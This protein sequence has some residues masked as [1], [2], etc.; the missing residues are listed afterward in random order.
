M[1]YFYLITFVLFTVVGAADFDRPDRNQSIS[2]FRIKEPIKIDGILD[3]TVWQNGHG[4]TQLVQRDPEEGA[5]PTEKTE[6][7]IAYD[8]Q[9]LYIGARLYDSSPESISA[10]LERRDAFS[11]TDMFGFFIDPYFD[12]R[13]GY[14]FALS[15]G[16]TLHDGILLNDEWDDDSWD[17]VWEGKT[18]IDDQGWNAEMRIPFSQLRFKKQEEYVWGINFRR[19]IA[20]KN[21]IIYL[22]Y[23]PRNGSGFV[24][25]FPKLTGIE[26]INPA[27]N[28]EVM[29]YV[30]AKGEFTHPD[31]GD[32]FNDGSRYLPGLGVDI[33]YGLSSNLTLNATV[34]PDFGQVEVDPAVINL[35]DVETYFNEK[36]PFFVEGSSIF[37]FGSGGSR[38]NWGFNWGNPGF[39]YSRRIGRSPQGRL[40]VHDYRDMP[41]GARILGAA[42]LTGKVGNNWNIGAIHAISAREFADIEYEGSQSRVE[43]EPLTHYSVLRVQKEMNEGF[44]GLGF[45]ST[46]AIRDFNDPRLRDDINANAYVF[47]LD[48]WTFLDKGRTW[49][50]TTWGGFS[51]L[52]GSE[53]RMLRVQTDPGHYFQR[54]DAR[55]LSPDSSATSLQGYAGRVTVNKQKG[56]VI[57]NSALGVVDPGFDVR[58][59]GFMWRTNV[60]NSHI[61]LGYKWTRPNRISRYTEVIG[62]VFNSWDFDGLTT[63]RGVF[64][65]LST[66]FVNYYSLNANLAYNPQTCNIYRTRGGPITLN[67]PGYQVSLQGSSDDRKPLVLGL[68]YFTYIVSSGE[69]SR[70]IE[71]QTEWKPWSNVSVRISPQVEWRNDLTQWVGAFED[72][73]ASETYGKRYVFASLDYVQL[74]SSLRLNWTFTPQLSLQLYMQPLIVTA[75]Y[76]DY[77]Y[78]AR[79]KSYDF[80]RFGDGNSTIDQ[81]DDQIV[82]DPDGEGAAPPLQWSVPDFSSKS[83]RGN[84][85]LRWE[86]RPGSAL[87]L[88]WTQSRSHWDDAGDF[89]FNR[90]VNDMISAKA[91]N[92]LMMKVTYWLN[93]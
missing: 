83:L 49:V 72:N 35:S 20:R 84:A 1:K 54:P 76:F 27:G 86:Y 78:L 46:S 68:G 56:N 53:N 57:F 17:G 13:S 44:R 34:N 37:A 22:V 36:R 4:I 7:R 8:D 24:S 52:N 66:R 63:W 26:N 93:L 88:V 47:G 19:D 69:W 85:V 15:A 40:P 9:A 73:T 64:G 51:H 80:V 74:S 23:T 11:T 79:S 75:D 91:D 50:V 87:Y 48:G 77:K 60:I 45:I 58:D 82:A 39:F 3:E 89:R 21:E 70:Q 59:V 67:K 30:R 41:D 71:L 16:G 2:A 5:E 28:W 32:P 81:T 6:I 61:G 29:P 43:V 62:A 10:R 12:R 33:K 14:F 31:T 42:K 18:S 55:S 90:S 65:M 92:I 38:N 25:R